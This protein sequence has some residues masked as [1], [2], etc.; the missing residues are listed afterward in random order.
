MLFHPSL[1][2]NAVRPVQWPLS[3]ALRVIPMSQA[4]SNGGLGFRQVPAAR[5]RVEIARMP[6]AAKFGRSVRIRGLAF[7]I[8]DK[9]RWETSRLF[10]KL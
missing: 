6:G 10:F 7:V 1:L 8:F 5:C 2:L 3:E 4:D 9:A